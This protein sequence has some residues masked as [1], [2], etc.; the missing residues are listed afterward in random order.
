METII[1]DLMN[2]PP[3]NLKIKK[4]ENK[5]KMNLKSKILMMNDI[6]DF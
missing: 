6:I 3:L 2:P 5:M 1:N 4:K